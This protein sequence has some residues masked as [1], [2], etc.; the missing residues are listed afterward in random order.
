MGSLDA[1]GLQIVPIG[2]TFIADHCQVDGT[3][4]ESWLD[5]VYHSAELMSEIT[6][7]VNYGSSDHLPVLACLNAM[8]NRKQYKRK[9]L[10]R[11]M[12]NFTNSLRMTGSRKKLGD[13]GLDNS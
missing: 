8:V 6:K 5:H 3:I 11:K 13:T 7:I 10:K 9:I 4:A 1:S 2:A 12:K